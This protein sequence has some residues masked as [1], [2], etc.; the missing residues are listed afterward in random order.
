[1][2]RIVSTAFVA[3]HRP[4]N[5]PPLVHAVEDVSFSPSVGLPWVLCRC[6]KV[7]HAAKGP[8]NHA[9]PD[10]RLVAAFER[11]RRAATGGRPI[12][13]S[14]GAWSREIARTAP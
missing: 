5:A 8:R 2:T 3:G 10:R 6:G 13:M 1:M 7:R 9:D 4:V 14:A 11:H 12:G